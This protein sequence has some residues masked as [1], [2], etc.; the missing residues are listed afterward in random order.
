MILIFKS[1]N[2][3]VAAITQLWDDWLFACHSKHPVMFQCSHLSLLQLHL[4]IEL[5]I[6]LSKLLICVC[7]CV[8]EHLSLRQRAGTR[9][10]RPW[11]WAASKGEVSS[12]TVGCSS[13]CSRTSALPLQRDGAEQTREVVVKHDR[14]NKTGLV[15]VLEHIKMN[16]GHRWSFKQLKII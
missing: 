11:S 13:R 1:I 9:W 12:W 10:K 3:L 14:S 16:Y 8:H 2:T 6:L 15:L 7:V 4:S 5:K